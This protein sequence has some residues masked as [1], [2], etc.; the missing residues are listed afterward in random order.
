MRI[1]IVF[2]FIIVV[3]LIA[4]GGENPTGG[5]KIVNVKNGA[6]Q[7]HID[8]LKNGKKVFKQYCVACHG[9]DGRLGI[10][11]AKNFAQS[12]LSLEERIEVITNGRGMMTSF[13]GILKSEQIETAAKYTIHLGKQTEE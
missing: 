8:Q 10:N 11:G 5:V 13:K 6:E 9:M 4:C 1:S 12:D 7:N 2:T 3:I